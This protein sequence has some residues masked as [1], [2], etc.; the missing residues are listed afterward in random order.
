[1]ADDAGV[2][3]LR[4]SDPAARAEVLWAERLSHAG[5]SITCDPLSNIDVQP[6][7]GTDWLQFDYACE[8]ASGFLGDINIESSF[9]ATGQHDG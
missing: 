4:D 9:S 7:D 1:M 3:A 2:V 6:V 5:S 8:I